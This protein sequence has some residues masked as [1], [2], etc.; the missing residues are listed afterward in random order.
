MTDDRGPKTKE[1]AEAKASMEKL[2]EQHAAAEKVWSKAVRWTEFLKKVRGERD[3]ARKELR[4][5]SEALCGNP[6]TIIAAH[7][8]YVRSVVEGLQEEQEVLT[9]EC[10]RLKA[11]LLKIA[12]HDFEPG[13]DGDDARAWARRCAV[14]T[15]EED[16]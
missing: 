2:A 16:E 14:N 1:I 5:V 9:K 13:F 8:K 4:G 10:S 15:E 12:D 6:D 7:G 11:A 3:L